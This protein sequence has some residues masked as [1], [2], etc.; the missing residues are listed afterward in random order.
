MREFVL[1]KNVDSL[2]KAYNKCVEAM[3]SL[4][5]YHLEI[6]TS[7]IV[8]PASRQPK[9]PATSKETSETETKGT[10]GTDVMN[11]LKNVKG[12]TEEALL[13]DD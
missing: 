1:L 11:F 10:G 2:T 7:Y 9:N 3:V 8:N 5:K 12:T 13:K 4:R 6:V